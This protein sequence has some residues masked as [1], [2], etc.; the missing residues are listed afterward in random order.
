[1]NMRAYTTTLQLPVKN[2]GEHSNGNLEFGSFTL[3]LLRN[4][5]ARHRL[6]TLAW[7]EITLAGIRQPEGQN[8]AEGWAKHINDKWRLVAQGCGCDDP[9]G[10]ARNDTMLGL[11]FIVLSLGLAAQG[12]DAVFAS[13]GDPLALWLPKIADDN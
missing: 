11:I 5:T 7:A 12:V 1:M 10:L 8:L 6:G 4:A 2:I 13:D 9:H 3:R